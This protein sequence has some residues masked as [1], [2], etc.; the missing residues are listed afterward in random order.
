MLVNVASRIMVVFCFQLLNLTC[1]A[2]AFVSYPGQLG[3][4]YL[5]ENQVRIEFKMGR[6]LSRHLFLNG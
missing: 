5:D 6:D 2:F 1:S 3:R 4:G